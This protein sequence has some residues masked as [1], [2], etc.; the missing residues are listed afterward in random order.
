MSSKRSA[1]HDSDDDSDDNDIEDEDVKVYANELD[2]FTQII[3]PL[4]GTSIWILLL[5]LILSI[6]FDSLCLLAPEIIDENRNLIHHKKWYQIEEE[7]FKPED[8]KRQ[9]GLGSPPYVFETINTFALEWQ[10][11]GKYS[12][13]G[14]SVTGTLL[15]PKILLGDYDKFYRSAKR[16]LENKF[17]RTFHSEQPLDYNWRSTSTKRFK[18]GK[19]RVQDYK[20]T[21]RYQVISDYRQKILTG[22]L[23]PEDIKGDRDYQPPKFHQQEVDEEYN[24]DLEEEELPSSLNHSPKDH[25]EEGPRYIIMPVK[26]SFSTDREE[27][28][29]FAHSVVIVFD[30]KKAQL[31]HF[32]PNGHTSEPR[33]LQDE[34][35]RQIKNAFQG[36]Y[37][38]LVYSESINLP[39]TIKAS[40][41]VCPIGPQYLQIQGIQASDDIERMRNFIIRNYPKE[42]HEEYMNNYESK[43]ANTC[44]MWSFVFMYLS[45]YYP[46]ADTDEIINIM[47]KT[48]PVDLH[49]VISR[50]IGGFS[51]LIYMFLEHGIVNYSDI[52]ERL[53]NDNVLASFNVEKYFDPPS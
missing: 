36:F 13:R 15:L 38:H 37:K 51:Y 53:K 22:K 31:R 32:D 29:V 33:L 10:V 11:V 43:M 7:N 52:V 30:R 14:E 5:T 17:T 27:G 34:M 50:L 39:L 40:K 47:T 25:K 48:S 35:L 26:M 1:R 41:D 8:Y 3:D 23:Y 46:N 44:S 49:D 6:K 4:M 18:R 19:E 45:L 42:K 12:R 20:D 28:E 16:C 2:L 24:S 9:G 21:A